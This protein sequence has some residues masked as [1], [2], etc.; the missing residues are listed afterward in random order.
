MPSRGLGTSGL[1]P[2]THGRSVAGTQAKVSTGD[3]FAPQNAPVL[4]SALLC[5]RFEG[6]TGMHP[7]RCYATFIPNLEQVMNF[8]GQELFCTDSCL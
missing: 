2:C 8:F 5:S 7:E 3:G 6:V 4:C 1:A